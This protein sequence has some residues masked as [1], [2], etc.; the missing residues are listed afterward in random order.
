MNNIMVSGFSNPFLT[1]TIVFIL[2][3]ISNVIPFGGPPYTIVTVT[4][5]F[6]I[7]FKYYWLFVFIA[8]FGAIL[9]KIVMFLVGKGFSRQLGKNKNVRLIS[10]FSSKK[11]FYLILF[12]LAIIPVL[13]FDDYLFIAGGAA[14]I[15]LIK[16]SSIVSIAK[17]IKTSLEIYIELKIIGIFSYILSISKPTIAVL[18]TVLFIAVGIIGFKLDWESIVH[19]IR[20]YFNH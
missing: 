5:L 15:S 1:S 10:K 12:I 13:P 11:I 16:M 3:F 14:N 8:S 20:A 9:S 17:L 19:K 4:L 7:G 18:L 2:S 6:E